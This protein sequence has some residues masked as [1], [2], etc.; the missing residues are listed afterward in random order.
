MCRANVSREQKEAFSIFIAG[1]IFLCSGAWISVGS[2]KNPKRTAQVQA[3][4]SGS[5]LLS[6]AFEP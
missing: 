1:P 4:T 2:P 3:T 6:S 5:Q